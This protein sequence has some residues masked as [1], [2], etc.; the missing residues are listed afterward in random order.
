MLVVLALALVGCSSG[1]SSADASP[2]ATTTVDLP[3][4]YRFEP[5]AI[6]IAAGSTVTWTN[7]D[8]FSHNVRFDGSEPLVMKPGE[9]VRRRFDA[10]GSFPYECSFHPRGMQGSVVVTGD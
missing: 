2:V 9:S 4:S 6:T 1:G 10:A 8:N 7:S 3:K 5:V